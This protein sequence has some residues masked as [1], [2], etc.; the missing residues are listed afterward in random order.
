MKNVF[1]AYYKIF[2]GKPP[3]KPPAAEQPVE[4]AE[5]LRK[6]VRR[7]EKQLEEASNTIMLQ[8][9][10]LAKWESKVK[11]SLKYPRQEITSLWLDHPLVFYPMCRGTSFS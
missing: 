6:V 2:G 3:S 7:Y 11:V 5:R 10:V 1:N 4:E 9:K 8:D